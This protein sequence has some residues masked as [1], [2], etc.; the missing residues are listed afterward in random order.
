[1][2][3]KIV[4]LF[5]GCG[6]FAEGFHRENFETVASIDFHKSSCETMRNRLI[7]HGMSIDF[8]DSIVIN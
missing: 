5:S 6:G 8:A 7:K 4:D 1:M 3:L 2:K